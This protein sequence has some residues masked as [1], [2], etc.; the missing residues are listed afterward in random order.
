MQRTSGLLRCL[1][2]RL[3]IASSHARSLLSRRLVG[4]RLLGSLL[5]TAPLVLSGLGCSARLRKLTIRLT[6]GSTA[7]GTI[8]S[9]G[10]GLQELDRRRDLVN[11]AVQA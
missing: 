10:R 11:R 5:H 4:D 3:C 7:L 1:G 2:P 9:G 8:S 6:G